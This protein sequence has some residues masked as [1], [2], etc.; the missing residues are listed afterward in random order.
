M[1]KVKMSLW[2]TIIAALL[3]IG[4]TNVVWIKD[5][6]TLG[7]LILICSLLSGSIIG[8]SLYAIFAIN[9]FNREGQ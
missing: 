9:K 2:T 4:I 8:S 1:R 7:Q 6:L 5:S 3:I